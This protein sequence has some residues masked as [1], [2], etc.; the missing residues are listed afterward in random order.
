MGFFNNNW[1][2]LIL[3]FSLTFLSFSQEKSLSLE[4]NHIQTGI[5][6]TNK[7]YLVFSGFDS[8]FKRS[9]E[10]KVWVKV[11]YKYNALPLS[12][13]FPYNYFHAKNKNYL[14]YKG[15]GEVYELRNDSI[16]RIDNSFKHK[17]QFDAA[18]F[19]YNGE[20]YFF[21]GYG[22]F[23][24]KNILTKFDFKTK[25]WELVK[26]SNYSK[27]PKPRD[28]AIF[29]L[30]GDELY[31]ISGHT[32]ISNGKQLTEN[33]KQLFDVWKLNLKTKSWEFLEHLNNEAYFKNIKKGNSYSVDDKFYSD[34]NRLLNI[35]ITNNELNL[36]KPDN[37]FAIS[38]GEKYNSN[39]KEIIY[40]LP[41]TNDGNKDV[42]I[43]IEPFSSY[44]NSIVGSETLLKSKLNYLVFGIL[45]VIIIVL[46]LVFRK[47]F[48]MKPKNTIAY[49]KDGFYFKTKAITN[50][51]T[52]EN[53]ML[54]FLFLN[55]NRKVQ[56]SELIEIISDD[57]STNYNTLSKKKDLVFNSLKQ[58]LAFILTV[59]ENDLFVLSR[60]QKD[61]RIKE[62]RLNKQYFD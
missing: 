56:V 57:N 36:Y 25:E 49:K 58:K 13:N 28:K 37:K 32:K 21:G 10:S 59:D 55:K 15:C 53:I 8:Y 40:A 30:N 42:E 38:F 62:I 20:I 44:S 52:D 33:S 12:K 54:E 19:V 34:Y 22:L 7:N 35:D 3:L 1:I 50:L 45:C 51:T 41:N 11:N 43:I 24:F 9:F 5:D 16:V 60:N 23:T 61:K 2:Y 46:V 6:T 17:N 14:A 47:R 26:Y 27:V 29:F 4:N 39:T 48:S 31:I 18:S